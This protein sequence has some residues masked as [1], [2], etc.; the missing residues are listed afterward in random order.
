MRCVDA[1]SAGAIA[2]PNLWSTVLPEN[3]D[4]RRPKAV[5]LK[6]RKLLSGNW[7]SKD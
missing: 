2:H 1:R 7:R 3:T 4:L 5:P 6:V